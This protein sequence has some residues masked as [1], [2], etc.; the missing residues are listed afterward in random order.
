MFAL[1][2]KHLFWWHEFPRAVEILTNEKKLNSN[3]YTAFFKF[4][5]GNQTSVQG[6]KDVF[7]FEIDVMENNIFKDNLSGQSTNRDADERGSKQ[8]KANIFDFWNVNK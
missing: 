4:L 5:I 8:N 2:L 6:E 7:A 1:K 3:C